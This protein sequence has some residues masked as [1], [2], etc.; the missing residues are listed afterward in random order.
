MDN[1]VSKLGDELF[2]FH[3]SKDLAESR[4][5][6]LKACILLEKALLGL[7]QMPQLLLKVMVLSA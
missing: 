7:H 2:K 4:S 3:I 6:L 1:D 5:L